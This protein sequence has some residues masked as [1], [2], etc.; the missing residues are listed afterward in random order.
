MKQSEEIKELKDRVK[1]L[2]QIN[3]PPSKS[4]P[5]VGWYKYIGGKGLFPDHPTGIFW[6]HKFSKYNDREYSHIRY[7]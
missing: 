2:E 5:Q 4:Q 3:D 7:V 1:K 6:V